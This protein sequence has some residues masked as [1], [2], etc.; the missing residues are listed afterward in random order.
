MH[1]TEHKRDACEIPP[2]QA[3]NA[4]RVCEHGDSRRNAAVKATARARRRQDDR[5]ASQEDR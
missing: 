5:R 2:W 1:A 3:R 4:D